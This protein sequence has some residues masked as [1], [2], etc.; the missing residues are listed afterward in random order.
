MRSTKTLHEIALAKAPLSIV[1]S[2]PNLDDNP[3]V[4]VNDAFTRLTGYSAEMAVGRNCRF[5]QGEDTEP[6]AV[7]R[8]REGLK[9]KTDFEVHL[10]NYRA[11]GSRFRNHIIVTP[12]LS[13]YGEVEFFLAL[14][15]P[16][17][18]AVSVDEALREVHHRVKNHLA[19]VVGM[20]RM[21]A[22]AEQHSSTGNYLTLARRIETLQ[23]L[24]NEMTASR[25]SS[26]LGDDISLGAYISRIASAI[27]YLDGREGVRMNLQVDD[28]RAPI[29][30]AAQI[31]LVAS[32]LLTNAYQHAFPKEHSGLIEVRLKALS[33][34]TVR[35]QVS[36]DGIGLPPGSHW[37]DKSSLGGKIV[38]SLIKG[39]DA[40]FAIADVLRGSEFTVDVPSKRFQATVSDTADGPDKT[41]TGT[42]VSVAPNK[43]HSP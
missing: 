34:G 35:L 30:T 40:K 2:N 20:I 11:D 26:Q 13:S 17:S 10:W 23:F 6:E 25:Y 22:R 36:D 21:Q 14:Q 1:I 32:E 16:V 33:D 39:L 9:G 4:F 3:I 12:L 29:D 18:G 24:Y 37:P 41:E 38:Q 8:F 28:L 15:Q 31:G 27:G 5:L 43:P 7:D 42:A 19:M